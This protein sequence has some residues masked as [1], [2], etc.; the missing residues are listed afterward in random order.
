M[1]SPEP[2]GV[3][4]GNYRT[5]TVDWSFKTS[6]YPARM[7][8]LLKRCKEAMCDCYYGQ[9]RTTSEITCACSVPSF[10]SGVN[11]A[12]GSRIINCTA[13][14][15]AQAYKTHDREYG[16]RCS[17]IFDVEMLTFKKAD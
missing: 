5:V 11:L 1:D 9:S 10:T 8:L 3:A 4:S 2:I 16:S 17:Q 15:F 13:Q 12:V 14:I 7:I 6:E